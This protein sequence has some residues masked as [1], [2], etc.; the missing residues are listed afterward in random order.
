MILPQRLIKEEQQETISLRRLSIEIGLHRDYLYQLAKRIKTMSSITFIG[1]CPF[2]RM[3]TKVLLKNDIPRLKRIILNNPLKQIK[4]SRSE[5][6][7]K[8]FEWANAGKVLK[9]YEAEGYKLIRFEKTTGI[10]SGYIAT[11]E[12]S[13]G[14]TIKGYG[15]T[16]E[17]AYHVAVKY[18][19][20]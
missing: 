13:Y 11:V 9:N 6:Y 4:G 5:K 1:R 17:N 7:L 20:C 8:L 12:D 2:N 15:K 16:K 10:A 19:D 18:G 14:K 3:K